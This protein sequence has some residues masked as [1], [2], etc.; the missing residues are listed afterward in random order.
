MTQHPKNGLT[1]P[2]GLKRDKSSENRSSFVGFSGA[3]TVARR[4]ADGGSGKSPPGLRR[5]QGPG[6]HA[7]GTGGSA[8]KFGIDESNLATRRDFIRLGEEERQPAGGVDSLGAIGCGQ[9]AKEFYDWQFEFG[10]TR[11]FFDAYAQGAGMPISQLRPAL[12]RAQ[13]GYFTQIFEAPRRTGGSAI[14]APPQSRRS[15]RQDQPSVQM[16]YRFL[17]RV[18]TVGQHPSARDLQGSEGGPAAEQAISKVFNYDMQAISDAF[19][20][21]YVRVDGTEPGR[22]SGCARSG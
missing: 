6:V 18:P 13:T 16:V 1:R 2:A 10:S 12:E 11:R 5:G 22:H 8:Q 14:R 17:H 20:D 15:P 3:R 9:I 4:D 19:P 7:P 21:E